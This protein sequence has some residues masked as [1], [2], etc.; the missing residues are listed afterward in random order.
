MRHARELLLLPQSSLVFPVHLGSN[1]VQFPSKA[2]AKLDR[3]SASPISRCGWQADGRLNELAYFSICRIPFTT[4][5]ER[6]DSISCCENR[7]LSIEK[8]GT[9]R[10]A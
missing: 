7:G 5:P 10:V 8:D 1:D 6:V 9:Q 2:L 4:A 3:E